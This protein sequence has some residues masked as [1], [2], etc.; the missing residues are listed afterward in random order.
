MNQVLQ[1]DKVYLDILRIMAIY[2]VVYN[3]TPGFYGE[4]YAG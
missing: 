1:R 3:H 4:I 2:L